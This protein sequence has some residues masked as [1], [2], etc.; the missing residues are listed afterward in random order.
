[1]I[2][3]ALNLPQSVGNSL[4]PVWQTISIIFLLQ[5]VWKVVYAVQ[6]QRR[7]SRKLLTNG[8]HSL[9]FLAEAIRGFIYIKFYHRANSRGKYA[10]GFYHSI[11]ND[12]DGHIPSPLIM[13]TC[14]AL[15]HALVEWQRNKGVH[16]KGSKSKLKAERPDRSNYF[17]YMNDGGK[18]ASCSR[19]NGSQVVNLAWCCRHVYIPDENLEHTTGELPTE[20]V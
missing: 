4:I 14:T 15:R 3:T 18:T 13:I 10:D 19:C 12:K 11:V 7:D 8:Q 1:M 6:I 17:N 20:G 9:F 2:S 5:S 16:P